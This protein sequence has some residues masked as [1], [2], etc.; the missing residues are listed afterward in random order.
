DEEAP[1]VAEE[2]MV[3][4]LS[5]V[6]EMA[7]EVRPRESARRSRAVR[8]EPVA[9][10]ACRMRAR[11]ARQ[12]EPLTL[13]VCSGCGGIRSV[14]LHMPTGKG[15][16]RRVLLRRILACRVLRCRV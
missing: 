2:A 9:Q 14:S 6:D 1:E 12:A 4:I 8:Q 13:R 16:A 11:N 15:V 3:M 7:L 5:P 10:H